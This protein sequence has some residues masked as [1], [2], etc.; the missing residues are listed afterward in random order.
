MNSLNESSYFYRPKITRP[1]HFFALFLKENPVI[2]RAIPF[3][4]LHFNFKY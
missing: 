1:A 2:G 3:G 4:R